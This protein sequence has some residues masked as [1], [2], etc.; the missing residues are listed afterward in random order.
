V[1]IRVM[2]AEEPEEAAQRGAILADSS[3]SAGYSETPEIRLEYL[4]DGFP[5]RHAS[6]RS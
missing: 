1:H 4:F 3:R 2:L 6:E 5:F